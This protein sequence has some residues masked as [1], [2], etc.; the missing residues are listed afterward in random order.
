MTLYSMLA[1]AY[2][3]EADL[4]RLIGQP[5]IDYMRTTPRYIPRLCPMKK[6]QKIT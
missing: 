5:Y 2:F 1:V 6:S 3:E 4:V